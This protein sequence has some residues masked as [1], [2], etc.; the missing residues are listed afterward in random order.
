MSSADLRLALVDTPVDTPVVVIWL[1]IAP[2]V[3]PDDPVES[4]IA[5][6]G[7]VPALHYHLGC[8]QPHGAMLS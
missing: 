6:G 3:S 2:D 7:G 4:L 1:L 8:R 5:R